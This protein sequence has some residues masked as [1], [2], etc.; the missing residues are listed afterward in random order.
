MSDHPPTLSSFDPAERNATKPLACPK[1]GAYHPPIV[2]FMRESRISRDLISPEALMVSCARCG[3]SVRVPPLDAE[4]IGDAAAV[5]TPGCGDQQVIPTG[6][7]AP[8]LVSE[9]REFAWPGYS[10]KHEFRI[11]ET[12]AGCPVLQFRAPD[13]GLHGWQDYGD[14][15]YTVVTPQ[16]ISFLDALFSSPRFLE[17]RCESTT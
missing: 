10:V 12:C 6:A 2:K 7:L 4:N 11:R 14:I 1:C 9:G 13:R 8:T 16:F 15:G 3:Y 17:E 5:A